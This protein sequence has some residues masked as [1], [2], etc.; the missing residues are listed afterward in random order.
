MVDLVQK[1]LKSMCILAFELHILLFSEIRAHQHVYQYQDRYMKVR[2]TSSP[3]EQ[4]KGR[5]P[6]DVF[7]LTLVHCRDIVLPDHTAQ[8]PC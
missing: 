4:Q 8:V 2:K 3:Q 1:L 5:M 7:I 6:T